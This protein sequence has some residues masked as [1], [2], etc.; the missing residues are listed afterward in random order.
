LGHLAGFAR[1]FL[2]AAVRGLT[3]S[4]VTDFRNNAPHIGVSL[5]MPGHVG[6]GI[7]AN[8][9]LVQGNHLGRTGRELAKSFLENAPV[10]A[11]EAATIILN[12]VK[13]NRW[14]VLVGKDAEEIDRMVREKP[15]EIY[16]PSFGEEI[17]KRGIFAQ[18]PRV[19]PPRA[20][21]KL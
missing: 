3:E 13:A 4:L 8:T 1:L 12:G 2:Q 21:E 6:T 11:D 18:T 16:E 5:V 20:Q 14:R 7:Y 15:E 9:V 19:P 10:S 17:R